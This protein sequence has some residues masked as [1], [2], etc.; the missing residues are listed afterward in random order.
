[1]IMETKGVGMDDL[2]G[3][4]VNGILPLK[5][6]HIDFPREEVYTRPQIG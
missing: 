5:R 4:K 2:G 6:A 1:M 3:Q